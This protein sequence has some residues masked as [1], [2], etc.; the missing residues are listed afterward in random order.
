MEFKSDRRLFSFLKRKIESEH[1]IRQIIEAE[2]LR[3]SRKKFVSDLG[4]YYFY[5]NMK[6]LF[7]QLRQSRMSTAPF[8]FL[9]ILKNKYAIRFGFKV[10]GKLNIEVKTRYEQKGANH[11]AGLKP[12]KFDILVFVSLDANYRCHFIGL[13]K[14]E[15]LK[16][17]RHNR[18]VFRKYASQVFWPSNKYVELI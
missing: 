1:S 9:G 5:I 3:F 13:I 8:D 14:K 10:N 11:L 15:R 12:D 2:G 16:V 6:G 7:K 18:I 4:E 17:D